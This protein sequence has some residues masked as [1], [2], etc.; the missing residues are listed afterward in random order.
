MQRRRDAASLEAAEGYHGSE[1]IDCQTN[2]SRR[3]DPVNPR[4]IVLCNLDCTHHAG[5][6]VFVVRDSD[7]VCSRKRSADTDTTPQQPRARDREGRSRNV[8][9]N[10]GQQHDGPDAV[11]PSGG[12]TP[13]RIAVSAADPDVRWCVSSTSPGRSTTGIPP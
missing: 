6:V 11:P 9:R 2:V 5:L 12:T 10:S 3:Y 13:T 1:R 7:C 4:P 8:D